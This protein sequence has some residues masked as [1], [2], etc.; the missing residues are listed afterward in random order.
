[1]P[2]MR[3]VMLGISQK[4]PA[5]AQ[6]L[7]AAELGDVEVGVAHLAGVVELHRDLGVALDARHGVDEDALGHDGLPMS[8]ENSQHDSKMKRQQNRNC[9]V[10]ISFRVRSSF[11][12]LTELMSRPSVRRL[13]CNTASSTARMRSAGGGQ[14]G[15][16]KSTGTT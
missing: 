15:M 5:L 6:P 2:Q 1:M 10:L 12:S 16:K 7:E 3:A 14:P 9:S 13:P 8:H 11:C 4:R